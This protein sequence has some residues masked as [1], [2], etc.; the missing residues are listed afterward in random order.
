MKLRLLNLYS[1]IFVKKSKFS[2]RFR[3]LK[4]NES[5]KSHCAK[6]TQSQIMYE[7]FISVRLIGQ[8]TRLLICLFLKRGQVNPFQE[9]V[10]F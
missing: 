8:V 9:D 7:R 1:G 6:V 3:N 4:K 10:F 5:Q 2:V